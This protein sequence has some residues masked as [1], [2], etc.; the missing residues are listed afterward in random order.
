[1]RPGSD[2]IRDL[3]SNIARCLGEGKDSSQY[4]KRE[5]GIHEPY[6]PITTPGIKYPPGQRR[7][8]DSADNAYSQYQAEDAAK[9]RSAEVLSGQS[10]PN[11]IAAAV[12]DP[13]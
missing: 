3:L 9:I 10:Y 5:G 2:S 4:R 13:E 6:G 8:Y 12:A 11:R 1:M 7:S